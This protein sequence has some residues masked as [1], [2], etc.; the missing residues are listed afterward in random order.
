MKF[1][2]RI[3]N[4]LSPELFKDYQESKENNKQLENKY[5][6]L[7]EE[8]DK[9]ED[10]YHRTLDYNNDYSRTIKELSNTNSFLVK[11]LTETIMEKLEPEIKK[12]SLDKLEF[13]YNSLNYE[14]I[15][16][17]EAYK[18]NKNYDVELEIYLSKGFLINQVSKEL[19]GSDPLYKLF[20][21]EDARATFEFSNGYDDTK[22]REY[23]YFGKIVGA[24]Y[25]KCYEFCKYEI[26]KDNPKYIEYKTK[27][28]QMVIPK[29]IESNIKEILDYQPDILTNPEKFLKELDK[30]IEE[31]VLIDNIKLDKEISEAI[32]ENMEDSEEEEM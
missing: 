32:E 19:L 2:N 6:N 4:F 8:Y 22:W 5:S 17:K 28:Y 1:K 20:P 16:L 15:R 21:E 23:Y 26:D 29:E 25:Y 31:K 14:D 11:K 27:L 7:T 24:E 12:M 13:L 3:I 18:D 30:K 9:L 10:D